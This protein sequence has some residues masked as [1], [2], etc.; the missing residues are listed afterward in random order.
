MSEQPPSGTSAR[1]YVIAAGTRHYTHL[2]ELPEAHRDVQRIA[3]LFTSMGYERVLTDVSY[4]PRAD[5][6][7]DALA[8]WCAGAEL[9][10]DDTVVLYYAGHGDLPD[11][12]NYRLACAGTVESRPRSWLSPRNLE[13][14]LGAS[15]VRNVLF[16]ID[17]CNAAAGAGDIASAADAFAAV[18]P[19]GAEGGAGTWVM[20]SARHRDL[21]D[22]GAFVAELAS[23]IKA[24]DGASQRYLSPAL[25]AH[26]VNQSFER[27]GRRQ[28][29]SCSLADQSAQPPFFSNPKFDPSA[30]TD[31][32]GRLGG[33]ASDRASHFEPRGRGVE[34]VSDPGSYFTGR[35]HALTALRT[36]LAATDE[37]RPLVVTGAPGSGKS[38]VLGKIVLE[39]EHGGEGEDG[40]ERDADN[41][42]DVSINMRHQTLHDV[43]QRLASAADVSATTVPALL[44]ALAGRRRPFRIVADSLDEAGPG[45]GKAEAR[46]IAWELL[47]PLAAVP[48]VRLVI[49]SRR[50]LLLH[51]G[52]RAPVIDLDSTE[53]ADDTSIAEYAERVLTDLGSPYEHAPE[54][55]RTVAEEVAAR[56]GRCFLVAR[57]TTTALMRDT[58]IDIAVPGWAERLP[59]DVNGALDA[60]LE[61]LPQGR[62]STALALLTALAFGEGHG[63]PRAGV[64]AQVASRLSGEALTEAHIDE[65]VD[66]DGSYLTVVEQDGRKYFRLYHQQLTTH[67][68]TRTLRFR[69]LADIQ[70]CF[71]DTLLD[72][73]PHRADQPHWDRA[74]PYVR[75]Y[76]ATHAAAAGTIDDLIEDPA[77]VL[78]ADVS[79]LLPAVRYARHA[80]VPALVIERC[81]DL[82]R[83][84]DGLDRPAQLAFVAETYG[85]REFALRAAALSASVDRLWVEPRRVT[86]HRIIG[87]HGS[88]NNSTTSLLG[89]WM[90]E[91]V[92]TSRGR[93]V[94]LAAPPSAEHVYVWGLDD[95]SQ[96][97]LLPH[98]SRVRNLLLLRRPDEQPLAVTLDEAGSLRVWDVEHQ[99]L[100]AHTATNGSE[101]LLDSG[102]LGNGTPVVLCRSP[103]GIEAYDP[104]RSVLLSLIPFGSSREDPSA[105]SV[106][107]QNPPTA[108]VVHD[109]DGSAWALVCDAAA[110]KVTLFPLESDARP[111]T[112]LRWLRS[113][114]ITATTRLRDGSTTAAIHHGRLHGSLTLIDVFTGHAT[115]HALP[116]GYGWP[117]GRFVGNDPASCVLVT[118]RRP[119]LH[120]VLLS[121]P[122]KPAVQ[123]QGD[124]YAFDVAPESQDG[125]LL[126]VGAGM[127]GGVSVI[128]A[129][130]GVA[131]GSPLH[132]HESAICAVHILKSSTSRALDIL[133]IGNDG[134]ARMWHWNEEHVSQDAPPDEEVSRNAASHTELVL[135]WDASPTRI[136]ASSWAGIRL[137]STGNLSRLTDGGAPERTHELPETVRADFERCSED[138][139]GTL[140]LLTRRDHFESDDRGWPLINFYW[141]RLSPTGAVSAAELDKPSKAGRNTECHVL[142][143]TAAHPRTRVLGFDPARNEVSISVSP[144]QHTVLAA[145][146]RSLRLD[147]RIRDLRST[148]FELRTGE[149]VLMVCIGNGSES[150]GYLWD[151]IAARPLRT[152]PIKLIRDVVAMVPQHGTEG[153]RYVAMA[154]KFGEAAVLDLVTWQI[155][156]VN[157]PQPESVGRGH[158]SLASGVSWYLRWAGGDDSQP[159]LLH[160][161]C[162]GFDDTTLVP[163]TVWDSAHPETTTLLPMPAYR[164]LWAG[165]A[166]NG[167]LMAAV[168]DEHGVAL[169]RLPSGE[170]VWGTPIPALVTSLAVL[171]GFD[172][173]ISTQQGVVLVRPRLPAPAGSRPPSTSAYC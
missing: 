83:A 21:A 81:S 88:G 147:I 45:D 74:H 3:D 126:A 12:G 63:L 110:G 148:A 7:E 52:D 134:T 37:R 57:M 26:R 55:A 164:L 169:C 5:D 1:R 113:P 36:H 50:E 107:W 49:G 122:A 102:I 66:E 76:L 121:A 47:R 109:R 9:T 73:V 85:A 64:W 144:R 14:V 145:M 150:Q 166:P 10:A 171:P 53:Y 59:S 67:L 163:V 111:R 58:P 95:P 106:L 139:D 60:Y 19:R 105:R 123:V 34:H 98:P 56:A 100:K 61:R 156:T 157:P 69:D 42:I 114:A 119:S 120:V 22:D 44:T 143:P 35:G 101:L 94:I 151:A 54:V 138:P 65:L 68:Q 167:E 170:K 103:R 29:A 79:G 152:D 4:D 91:E 33:D 136:A 20:A 15:G 104:L 25:L 161:D 51:I 97:A 18:R 24:G 131:V 70:R 112:L 118:A 75:G 153:S 48:C 13:A 38:A 154:A 96:S 77:F 17:A 8:D 129:E 142:P 87:Q 89:G 82:L 30:E 124:I 80:S 127:T 159:V 32:A 16:V 99:T 46:H 173:A 27:A 146:P 28:R 93:T 140:N 23:V 160:M 172:L 162:Q 135:G 165:T 128:N 137:I 155:H 62:R 43:V 84:G 125:R 78:A 116:D 2:P 39:G 86:P 168:S 133:S 130:T 149:V 71:V 72:L 90:I 11:A 158:R 31:T 141:Q 115:S 117:T 108:R 40:G 92:G 6:F 41:R 132:G